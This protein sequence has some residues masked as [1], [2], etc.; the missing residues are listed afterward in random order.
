[1]KEFNHLYSIERF[2]RVFVMNKVEEVVP[3]VISFDPSRCLPFGSPGIALKRE[4]NPESNPFE[5]KKDRVATVLCPF[6]PVAG[7]LP[8]T[9]IRVHHKNLYPLPP[10]N[11]IINHKVKTVDMLNWRDN[12]RSIRNYITNNAAITFLIPN[13]LNAITFWDSIHNLCSKYKYTVHFYHSISIRQRKLLTDEFIPFVTFI[14]IPYCIPILNYNKVDG[15][16]VY[17]GF[18]HMNNKKGAKTTIVDTLCFVVSNYSTNLLYIDGITINI[19][20][21]ISTKSLNHMMQIIKNEISYK[22][23]GKTNHSL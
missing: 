3:V 20:K 10:K 2:K 5:N 21:R 7:S 22:K 11:L 8:G 12:F 6:P 9:Y 19:P 23:Y 17:C 1:M 13:L 14:D 16:G 18:I 4:L 15:M